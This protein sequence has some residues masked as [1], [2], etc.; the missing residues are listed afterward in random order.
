[1]FWVDLKPVLLGWDFVQIINCI[2][3]VPY[4][5]RGSI[6]NLKPINELYEG[7]RYGTCSLCH[8][9]IWLWAN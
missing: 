7:I 3:E 9:G 4:I 8:C 6:L 5:S 1:M 2:L